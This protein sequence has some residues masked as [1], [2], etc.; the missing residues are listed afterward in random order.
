MASMD[1]GARGEDMPRGGGT[2]MVH[3]GVSTSWGHIQG[4][5]GN[6]CFG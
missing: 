5:Q 6:G 2:C 1:T 4:V 3:G